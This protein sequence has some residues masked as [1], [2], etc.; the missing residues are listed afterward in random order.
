MTT[1]RHFKAL[2]GLA[3]TAEALIERA[4]LTDPVLKERFSFTV[5]GRGTSEQPRR[6]G[7]RPASSA[8]SIEMLGAADGPRYLSA[9]RSCCRRRMGDI[10]VEPGRTAWLPGA[11]T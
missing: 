1:G 11:K 4:R 7:G 6:I 5:A 2:S 10:L 9:F 3:P 8:C